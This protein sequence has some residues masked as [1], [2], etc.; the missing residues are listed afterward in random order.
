MSL[1][2]KQIS[3][4]NPVFVLLIHPKSVENLIPRSL[5]PN[6]SAIAFEIFAANSLFP[7]EGC[8]QTSQPVPPG[9]AFK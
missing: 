5:N 8:N 3:G 4:S 1:S 7:Y 2:M 6:A 9:E